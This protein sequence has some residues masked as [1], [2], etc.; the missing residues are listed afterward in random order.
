MYSDLISWGKKGRKY[1]IY[2]Y[3][4]I[5]L[6]FKVQKRNWLEEFSGYFT[7][8][9]AA[10]AGCDDENE[11]EY[12]CCCLVCLQPAMEFMLLFFCVQHFIWNILAIAELWRNGICFLVIDHHLSLEAEPSYFWEKLKMNNGEMHVH[13]IFRCRVYMRLSAGEPMAA[14]AVEPPSVGMVDKSSGTVTSTLFLLSK[15]FLCCNL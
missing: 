4:L 15:P 14:L 6:I 13:A 8:N 1:H 7:E 10:D 9:F 3:C 11:V 12:C 2:I 5:F